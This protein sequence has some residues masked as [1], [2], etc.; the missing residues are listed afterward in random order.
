MK[1]IKPIYLVALI[2]DEFN[3]ILESRG[4][5]K[6]PETL[7]FLCDEGFCVGACFVQR[8]TQ[9]WDAHLTIRGFVQQI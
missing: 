6:L 8:V 3:E 2:C 1:Q 5:H 9:L 7:M 4:R